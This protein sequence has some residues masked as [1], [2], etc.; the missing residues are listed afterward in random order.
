[1][2]K[3]IYNKFDKESIGKL[4]QIVFPGKIITISNEAEAEKAVAY[5][6]DQDMLGIDT[7]T[8]PA[9]KKGS[10]YKV[11]LLQV[12]CAEV[13]FLF[14]LN[15]IGITAALKRLLENTR[16]PMIGLSLHDDILALRRRA[17]FVPGK[18]IDLQDLVG[19]LGIEDRS[20]QKLYANLFHQKISKRQRLTNWDAE[21]LTDKQKV[22]A[23]TDA[24]TCINLYKEIFR[25]DETHDFE[26]VK[27]P[28]PIAEVQ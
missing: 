18:F 12:S 28:E 11:S 4:P 14:R 20:L 19:G 25:L 8:R 26:L 15:I 21:V 24:W 9:F 7:E 1:M 17:A 22:Y 3:L 6:L 10:H 13:C 16:V 5:L 2:R 27:V 23:A